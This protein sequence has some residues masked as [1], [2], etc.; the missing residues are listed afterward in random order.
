MARVVCRLDIAMAP[1]W[2]ER[3]ER[4]AAQQGLHQNTLIVT[5]LRHYF[6]LLDKAGELATGDARGSATTN[7]L[8]CRV[9]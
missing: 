9:G 7:P 6:D 3:V 8:A 1:E 4:Y 5:A 2:K